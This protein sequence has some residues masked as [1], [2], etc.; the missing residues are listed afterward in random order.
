MDFTNEER[1]ASNNNSVKM[2]E[3]YNKYC[4]WVDSKEINP[5]ALLIGELDN[6]DGTYSLPYLQMNLLTKYCLMYKK[7]ASINI[8]NL[9]LKSFFQNKI[10][11]NVKH[12]D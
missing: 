3:L 4:N 9:N 5:S 10:C 11:R 8:F 2:I 7:F 12:S 1:K 6:G